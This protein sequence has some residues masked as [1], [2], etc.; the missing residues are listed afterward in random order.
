MHMN[1]L[2]TCGQTLKYTL[3]LENHLK[4]KKYVVI[5]MSKKVNYTSDQ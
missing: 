2:F 1:Q 4:L 3:F 5:Q